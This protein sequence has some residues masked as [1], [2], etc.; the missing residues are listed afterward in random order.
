MTIR[1]LK[2][3]P[4]IHSVLKSREIIRSHG[5]LVCPEEAGIRA[6]W[7]KDVRVRL[8]SVKYAQ[9]LPL[10][11]RAVCA[12]LLAELLHIQ[13]LNADVLRCA[14]G[15]GCTGRLPFRHTLRHYSG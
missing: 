8:C 2:N 4:L 1:N 12:Q 6:I 10:Q 7:W 9:R 13:L 3:K 5:I 15:C 14:N 11:L